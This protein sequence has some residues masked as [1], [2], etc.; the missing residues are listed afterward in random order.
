MPLSFDNS[1]TG[2]LGTT[3]TSSST[4][5]IDITSATVGSLCI[6]Q[7]YARTSTTAISTFTGWTSAGLAQTNSLST[8]FEVW[9]RVKQS[10][11]TTQSFTCS[12][13]AFGVMTWTSYLGV[14]LNSTGY[15]SA[16][17]T[18]WTTTTYTTPSQTPSSGYRW[19]V[20]LMG[21]TGGSVT[22]ITFPNP[23]GMVIRQQIFD[24]VSSGNRPACFIADTNGYAPSGAQ[25]YTSVPTVVGGSATTGAGALLF[26]IE[27]PLVAPVTVNK[28]PI[29]RA[30]LW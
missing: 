17:S 16:A 24:S 3:T 10:G 19:A 23:S 28:P 6:M 29:Q 18:K 8:D 9:T 14:Q 1:G 21:G 22:S 20:C 25:S 12:S 11:D 4:G 30:S 2:T 26:L 15:E 7:F 5:S 13:A 27:Q